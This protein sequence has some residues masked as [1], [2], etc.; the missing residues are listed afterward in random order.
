MSNWGPHALPPHFPVGSGSPKNTQSFNQEIDPSEK[1]KNL[2]SM[3]KK[4]PSVQSLGSLGSQLLR[5]KKHKST[6]TTSWNIRLTSARLR[7]PTHCP[8]GGRV[9]EVQSEKSIHPPRDTQNSWR[10]EWI[11][12][13]P[14]TSL[15]FGIFFKPK[16]KVQKLKMAVKKD[17]HVQWSSYLRLQFIAQCL[18]DRWIH[19]N[20]TTRC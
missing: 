9:F 4:L 12:G 16:K 5:K 13:A 10:R 15:K 19:P 14:V 7:C 1:F 3:S 6:N 2:T 18:W 11:Y 8:L 20:L 17:S